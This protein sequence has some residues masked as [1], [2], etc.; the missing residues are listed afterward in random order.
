MAY[1]YQKCR[2]LHI[3]KENMTSL[4]KNRKV[5]EQAISKDIQLGKK[6]IYGNVFNFINNSK[7]TN[8]I[9]IDKII[10]DVT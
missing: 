9:F 10:N 8:K 4:Q 3:S 6:K 1:H 5:F 7:R 2:L